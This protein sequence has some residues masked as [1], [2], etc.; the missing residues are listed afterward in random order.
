MERAKAFYDLREKQILPEKFVKRF[1]QEAAIVLWLT[2]KDPDKRPTVNELYDW[3]V[4]TIIKSKF[5]K[6][7]T[8]KITSTTD[9]ITTE[10]M[11]T[12]RII[13]NEEIDKK[14]QIYSTNVSDFRFL[15]IM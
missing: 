9:G 6:Q 1:P 7:S 11:L 14:Q 12:N 4:S 5:S 3:N 13:I 2:Q 8:T 15:I 10:D